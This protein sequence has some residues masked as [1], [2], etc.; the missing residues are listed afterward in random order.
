MGLIELFVSPVRRVMVLVVLV[1]VAVGG[2]VLVWARTDEPALA[3][4]LA[5][6]GLTVVAL[7]K[8]SL[9]IAVE[10]K[11]IPAKEVRS[12]NLPG[13]SGGSWI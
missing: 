1:I 6:I 3:I 7:A 12:L 2:A 4:V 13:F 5:V 8:V 10:Q 11:S 9:E